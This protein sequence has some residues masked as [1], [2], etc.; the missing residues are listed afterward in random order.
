MTLGKNLA[1]LLAAILVIGGAAPVLALPFDASGVAASASSQQ[2]AENDSNVSVT[3]GA[4]LSTVMA[5]T[6]DSLQ[7]EFNDEVF[8]SQIDE[9]NASTQARIVAKRIERLD[10]RAADIRAE[11]ERVT[12]QYEAGDLTRAQ[13]AQ[14]L[15]MLNARAE[16]VLRS[17]DQTET[18]VER[19]SGLDLSAVG[20][21]QSTLA[22]A[23]TDLEPLTGPGASALQKRFV[24]EGTG[25][26]HLETDNGLTIRVE[27]GDTDRSRT[28]KHQRDDDNSVSITQQ[29][30]L[31]AAR[32]ALRGPA[33]GWQLTKS[34]VNERR[35]FYRFEFRLDTATGAGTATVLVDAS[36]GTVFSLDESL[37]R[38]NGADDKRQEELAL[39]VAQG[40]AAPGQEVTIQAF[41]NGEV[42]GDVAILV[43]GERVG[44]TNADG[45]LTLTLPE[46]DVTITGVRGDAEGELEFDFNTKNQRDSV[47][48]DLDATATVEN[49][50]ATVTILYNDKPVPGALVFAEGREVGRTNAD[51]TV[52][53]ATDATDTLDIEVAKGKLGAAFTF[54]I[55]NGT[56]TLDGGARESDKTDEPTTKPASDSREPDST[57]T[58]N[59]TT[60]APDTVTQDPIGG[61]VT[62]DPANA[63]DDV[64]T[65][66]RNTSENVTDGGTDTSVTA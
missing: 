47:F 44:T 3:V 35:G 17:I 8:E 7:T 48:R 6:G 62:D 21:N 53:F 20:V 28:T 46:E 16:N 2:A 41:S 29:E 56:A 43:N 36:T 1:V 22:G 49:G 25:N 54:V 40:T 11:Y 63:T 15:A 51:G 59:T 12:A 57:T 27:D 32:D 55:E 24:G 33:D 37:K 31:D 66:V 30:A 5:T 50:V 10:A 61:N 18:R 23:A 13:Y 39:V 4:Q 38:G 42:A 65:A 34:S 9:A 19:L 45:Q 64:V 60:D 14:R 26:V 52:E 58:P